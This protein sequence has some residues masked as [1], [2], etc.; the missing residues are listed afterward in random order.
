M[1]VR[2]RPILFGY[3]VLAVVALLA[4]VGWVIW[5]SMGAG[6]QLNA[7]RGQLVRAE[8]EAA[9]RDSVYKRL[10][11]EQRARRADY[12]GQEAITASIAVQEAKE[13]FTA[14]SSERDRLQHDVDAE[15]A[16]AERRTLLLVPLIALGLLHVI[17][18]VSFRPGRN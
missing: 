12:V 2:V 9:A 18:A 7:L 8:T 16:A 4:L 14:A 15:R 3:C 1:S 13:S 10:E 17:G 5:F 6:Q 11:A